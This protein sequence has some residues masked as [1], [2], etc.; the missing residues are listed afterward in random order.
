[1]ATKQSFKISK[2]LQQII[3][4]IILIVIVYFF[5]KKQKTSAEQE[6]IKNS[7]TPDGVPVTTSTKSIPTWQKKYNALQSV[8]EDGLLKRG[9]KAKEIWQV[10]YLY[11]ENIAKK[12][13]KSKI[14]VDGIFGSQ[15][16]GAIRY[17]TEKKYNQTKLVYWR[18]FVKMKKSE[19]VAQFTTASATYNPIATTNPFPA[20]N[21]LVFNPYTF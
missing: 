4:A 9:M 6:Q 10:Q 1:M 2:Q 21:T 12:E 3:I 20:D 19:R 8:G 14:D 7:T 16:E 18:N 11:N 17:V 13:G 5:I 15:T